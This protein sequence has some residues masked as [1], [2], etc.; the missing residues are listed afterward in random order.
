MFNLYAPVSPT[1]KK[2][3]WDTLQSFLLLHNPENIIIAG[4]LNVTLAAE[5]KKGGSPVRDPAREWVEDIMISWDLEDIKSSAGKY[6]WSNKRLGP[7]HIAARL[8]RFLVQTSFLASGLM[9]SSKILPN[10]SFDHKP[11]SLELSKDGFL[12]PIP[13]RFSPLWIQPEGFHEVVSEVWNRHVLGSPFFV[14]EEK[15]CALKKRL[16]EWAKTLKTPAAKRKEALDNLAALQSSMEDSAVTQ[17]LLQKEVELQKALHKA[18]RDEEE[19]WRQKSRNLWLQAGNKNTSFFH[20]QAEAC[21]QFKNVSEI[22]SHDTVVKYF[23]GIKRAAFT[24]FKELYSATA[25]PPI[26]TNAY[27]ISLI[28]LCVQD[29]V[30]TMLTAPISLDELKKALDCMEPNKAPGPDGFTAR[31]LQ[32]C[33]PIINKDLLRMVRK[34]QSCS[35]IGG[36]TNSAFLALLLKE[37]G[38]SDFSRFHS[39]SLCN[40]SYKLITKIISIRLKNIL[41]DIIPEN[42]GGFIK[43]RKILDNIV[44]VQ[45][46]VHSSCQRKEKGMVIKLDLANAFDRVRHDFLFTVMKKMGFSITFI[47]WVKPCIG[48]PW[49]APLVHSLPGLRMVHNVKDIN[50]AQFADDTLL[51][52]GASIISARSFKK[53]LDIYKEASGNKINYLKSTIYG[54]N[55]SVKV[56]ADIARLLEMQVC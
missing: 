45:E 38:A 6:T 31:F 7:N 25:D 14:W 41:P 39:I 36:S 50:H 34:S 13:F 52:G 32:S 43:G 16:K 35:K 15:L 8:D 44:L 11:I 48:S 19:Y 27:P 1:E 4:D 21:K 53:E 10:C 55:Y 9:A 30:N 33:W 29:S 17:S 28:P 47:N 18:S 49:I 56:L 46:A 20:K 24:F 5:E 26:D 42:Q 40:T 12:G 22:R 2:F 37:K 54:W 3:C 51:L 23:E